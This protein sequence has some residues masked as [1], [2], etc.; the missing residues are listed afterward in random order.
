MEE[1]TKSTKLGRPPAAAAGA[2]AVSGKGQASLMKWTQQQQQQQQQQHPLQPEIQEAAAM[3]AGPRQFHPAL[4]HRRFLVLEVTYASSSSGNGGGVGGREKILM[5]LEQQQQQQQQSVEAAAAVA[6]GH[7]AVA[8]A[9][10]GAKD[11]GNANNGDGFT[12]QQRNISLQGDWYDC[13][14]EPGDVVHVLFP[15]PGAAAAAAGGGGGGGRRGGVGVGVARDARGR[16]Q[17]LR[18]AAHRPAGHPRVADEGGRRGA[19][20]AEGRAPVSAGLR[21][22]QE[23]ARH[24]GKPQARAVRDWRQ[25]GGADTGGGGGGGGRGRGRGRG[26]GGDD[27]LLTSQFMAEL[28]DR[29]VVSQLEALYGAGLDE[30]A[31]RRELLAVSESVLDWHR[32]FLARRRHG[33]QEHG[34]GVSSSSSSSSSGGAGAGGAGETGNACEG[35]LASLS[36][37]GPMA[38]RVTVS[39]VLATE[40]DVWSPVLGLKGIMD[41]TV[42]AVVRTGGVAPPSLVMPVEVKTG[43]RIGEANSSHRAQVMLYTLLLRMR[44]GH[45]ASTSGLLVYTA[46][47]ALHTELVSPVAAEIRA[48]VLA[49]NRHATGMAEIGRVGLVGDGGSDAG[50]GGAALP[51]VIR[52]ARECGMCFQNSECMLYHRAGEGGDAESSGLEGGVFDSKVGHLSQEHLDFFARWD[53][54]IDLE[55]KVGEQVRRTM[56]QESGPERESRTSK[57]MSGLVWLGERENGKNEGGPVSA[58]PASAGGAATGPRAA[59]AAG[60]AAVGAAGGAGGAAGGV[61]GGAETGARAGAVTSTAAPAAAGAAVPAVGGAATNVGG[62][63]FTHVF[64]REWTVP[65]EI[66]LRN[67]VAAAATRGGGGGGSG[68]TAACPGPTVL[69][70]EVAPTAAAAASAAASVAAGTDS[71]RGSTSTS[72]APESRRPK[73]AKPLTDLSLSVGDMVCVS[74]QGVRGQS[75]P[76]PLSSVTQRQRQLLLRR[77]RRGG[78]GRWWRGSSSGDHLDHVRLLTGNVSAVYEDRVEVTSDRRMRVPRREGGKRR[79]GCAGGGVGGGGCGEAEEVLDVEDLLGRG[80][81]GAEEGPGGLGGGGRGGQEEERVLFRIDKDEWAAGINMMRSNLVKLMAGPSPESEAAGDVKNGGDNAGDEKRRRLIV[82][83]E[84]PRFGRFTG[85]F[86]V[87]G[88]LLGWKGDRY[89]G[90]GMDGKERK[91]AF[92]SSEACCILSVRTNRTPPSLPPPLFLSSVLGPRQLEA[93]FRTALNEDQRAAVRKLVTAKDYALLLGMPG[94]GKTWTIAFA[95]RVLLA[96]GASVLITSY[97]HSAVDNLLLK[98]IEKGVPCLRVGNPSSVHPGVRSHCINYD[99]AAETTA[100]YSELVNS[101]RV[102]GCTCLGVKHPLFSH[103][104]FDYCVVDEAG[105][106]SQPVVLAPLRCADV[107]VLVGDHYQLPPLATSSEAFEAGMSESLFRRLCEAHPASLQQLSYQYRMNGDVMTLC[108]ELTYSGRLRCGNPRVEGQRLDLP[109]LGAIPPPRLPLPLPVAPPA[110]VTAA[111]AAA[112]AAGTAAGGTAAAAAFAAAGATRGAE[113]RAAAA[114]P[115]GVVARGGGGGGGSGSRFNDDPRWQGKTPPT[116]ESPARGSSSSS[117]SATAAAAAKLTPWLTE[118][119]DPDRRVA[120]LDT[121]ALSPDDGVGDLTEAVAGA[122]GGGGGG[123]RPETL[124]GAAAAGGRRGGTLVN[125]VECDLVRLL[126]WGLDVAG[127]DLGGVGVISPYRSQVGL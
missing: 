27:D 86:D 2:G 82:D 101:A 48:L 23:Q 69:T 14:V 62:K 55:A 18:E 78:G 11:N 41:A 103:R 68:A 58:S 34:H 76:S 5:A 73:W 10:S 63:R 124:W 110:A 97:T 65:D 24:P 9:P 50:G 112:A 74:A 92:S 1:F 80:G 36:T 19:L 71:R 33:G 84:T 22:E 70:L 3:A 89:G 6:D 107:F 12:G 87:P 28:V 32:S 117:P 64:S 7:P 109:N 16:G 8:G 93:M 37:S 60:G 100:A 31:A 49:R 38:A 52:R 56:W 91:E 15:I 120:F 54:T 30:D 67:N 96:R 126:A 106:I 42:E 125:A 39:R 121:D 26:G 4:V 122:G 113:A 81:G 20:H 40:D 53:R 105:Q 115:P 21:R 108:N 47:D 104:R 83:L 35:G 44:Y 111:A 79:S 114:A 95:V 72:D 51:P 127:F 75:S 116:P 85:L 25:G 45:E 118:V 61:A 43:K 119:L 98:L 66:L 59:A 102:V 77:R 88:T 90:A 123:G 13:E 99:G 46:A 57:C 29:I 17:R 94:T